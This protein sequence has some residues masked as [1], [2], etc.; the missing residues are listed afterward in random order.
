[1]ILCVLNP[2]VVF[3]CVFCACSAASASGFNQVIDDACHV[4]LDV[5]QRCRRRFRLPD[6]V[7]IAQLRDDL[8]DDRF[9]SFQRHPA[10]SAQHD[11]VQA[12]SRLTAQIRHAYRDRHQRLAVC[13]DQFIRPLQQLFFC[14]FALIRF[15]FFDYSVILFVF[16][17]IVPVNVDIVLA[18]RV[19]SR[20]HP[21]FVY[22][23]LRRLDVPHGPQ[24][25]A[26][27]CRPGC[28]V[29]HKWINRCVIAPPAVFK[30]SAHCVQCA[31]KIVSVEVIR[32]AYQSIAE[33]TQHPVALLIQDVFNG[34]L[35][36]AGC[37][38]VVPCDGFRRHR[39]EHQLIPQRVD[40]M[41]QHQCPCLCFHLVVDAFNPPHDAFS[42]LVHFLQ[43]V[44]H[45]DFR[46]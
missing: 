45:D 29:Q 18:D 8:F 7:R 21:A 4:F 2:G 19:E 1:M 22:G 5:C 20:I 38:A 44:A 39:S 30:A 40:H 14:R 41:L 46:G 35:R 37:R 23:D 10:H 34:F 43:P 24:L 28:D 3:F 13:V 42:R 32:I 36:R 25:H 33:R 26:H 6:L 11:V 15:G 9:V 17:Y 27:R 31:Q 16:A 12:L